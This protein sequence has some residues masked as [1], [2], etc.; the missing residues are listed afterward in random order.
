MESEVKLKRELLVKVL[1]VAF[2]AKRN[3]FKIAV[4]ESCTGG[5]ISE[6]LSSISGSSLWFDFGIVCYSNWAKNFFLEVQSG[7]LKK[8]GAVSDVVAL[9][10]VK[11]L[12]KKIKNRKECKWSTL[13]LSTTGITGPTGGGIEKPIGLVWFGFS[14]PEGL[15]RQKKIFKGSRV[16]IRELATD[17]ALYI[18][19]R[20]S[21]K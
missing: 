10:M 5:K 13:C 11:G 1:T 2:F 15:K 21:A 4:A 14:G 6:V 17:W 7:S 3:R 12:D 9:E 16:N 20:L 18:L 19:I 8:F